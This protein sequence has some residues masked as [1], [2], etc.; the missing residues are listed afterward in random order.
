MPFPS[1]A[2]QAANAARE[3]SHALQHPVHVAPF[4]QLGNA[5][6]AA[7]HKLSTVLTNNID[8]IKKTASVQKA[9]TTGRRLIPITPIPVSPL[10]NNRPNIIEDNQG[11]IPSLLP[12]YQ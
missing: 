1:S 9:T 8:Q 5:T 12:T 4:S 3:L 10:F 11:N 2:D 6:M 7:I